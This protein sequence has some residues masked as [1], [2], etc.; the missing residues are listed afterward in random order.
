MVRAVAAVTPGFDEE[1]IDVDDIGTQAQAFGVIVEKQT[2]LA[3]SP[4]AK[5]S[6]QAARF[7]ATAVGAPG[8]GSQSRDVPHTAIQQNNFFSAEQSA[9]ALEM[10]EMIRAERRRRQDIVDADVVDAD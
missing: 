7:S 8:F 2:E 9:Q 1:D 5:G 10:L 3:I 4:D 6:T